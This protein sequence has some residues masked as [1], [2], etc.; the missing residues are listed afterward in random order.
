MPDIGE[1][2]R[3]ARMRRRID[4]AEVEEATKIRAKY[5][6]A[7]ENEEWA[8]LPGSTY[9]KTFLRTY[10]DY[11][12][13]DSRRLV[14]EYKLRYEGPRAGE[15]AP[16]AG[17][18]PGRGQPRRARRR[19]SPG[20]MGPAIVVV[21]VVVGL[22]AAL[23]ALGSIGSGGGSPTV[24][25]PPASS[26]KPKKRHGHRAHHHAA[27]PATPKKVGLVLLATGDVYVCLVD[28]KGHRLID[29]QTLTAGQKSRRYTAGTLRANF[30]TSNVRMKV[31][32]HTYSVASSANPVGYE[33]RPGHKPKRL[34]D[35]ARPSC[36]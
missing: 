20:W 6:R 17:L 4:M 30:G 10:A 18:A 29:G 15:A 11:L 32:G 26:P 14:E 12:E 35:A 31:G 25:T 36:A 8:L 2:L 23:Y 22:L 19:R 5:L 28:G 33:L 21:L 7:L 1:T 3:E 16:F 9:V 27:T 34:A 24:T 13:L